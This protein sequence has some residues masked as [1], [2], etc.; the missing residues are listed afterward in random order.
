MDVGTLRTDCF[1]FPWRHPFPEP[2]GVGSWWAVLWR[3][4]VNV[5]L[6]P[7]IGMPGYCTKGPATGI[8]TVEMCGDK[9]P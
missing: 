8:Q 7:S 6:N 9:S 4:Q 2:P 3:A 5:F 1:V